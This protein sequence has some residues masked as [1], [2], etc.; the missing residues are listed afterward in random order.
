MKIIGLLLWVVFC[1]GAIGVAQ[2][3]E[4]SVNGGSYNSLTKQVGFCKQQ[5]FDTLSRSTSGSPSVFQSGK[6]LFGVGLSHAQFQKSIVSCGRCI[7]VISI[8]RFYKFNDELTEWDYNQTNHGNF[9][10]MVFDECTDAI[11]ESGFLDFDIYNERQP[12][13]YGNPTDLS[14]SFAPCPVGDDDKIEFLICLGYMSCQVQNP[15][16]RMVDDLY[17]QSIDENWFTLY[18]RNFR[19]SITN[20]KVQGVALEDN[21]SWVWKSYDN[22]PLQNTE[23]LIEWVNEDGSHQ[24]WVLNWEDYFHM[25]STNGYRGGFIVKTDIQN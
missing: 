11:C 20:I 5:S 25:T 19:I 23:W 1:A 21:Q 13:A 4:T 14:W 16:G 12:V 9:S 2:N 15:E 24:S 22:T 6:V 18:P 10:V 7:E 17:F 3:I 8:N